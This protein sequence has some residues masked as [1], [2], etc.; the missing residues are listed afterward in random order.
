M[1]RPI[2]KPTIK[3]EIFEIPKKYKAFFW[4]MFKYHHYLSQKLNKSARCFLATWNGM[5]VGFNSILRMPSGT[6]KNAW[7]EHRLV[8]L[9]DYQG[10]G[11]GNRLS[12]FV[13]HLLASEGKVFYSKTANVKLGKYRDKSD[14]WKATSKN[15]KVRKDIIKSLEDGKNYNNMYNK[16]VVERICYSHKYN[17]GENN[18]EK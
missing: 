11:I 15:R 10:L 14:K 4:D 12:E 9:C 3:I 8:V 16:K 18:E 7:R 13:G 5:P 2:K 6:I 1:I 17:N